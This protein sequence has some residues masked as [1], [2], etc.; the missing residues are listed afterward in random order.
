MIMIDDTTTSWGLSAVLHSLRG[1]PRY[2]DSHGVRVHDEGI[3]N[4]QLEDNFFSLICEVWADPNLPLEAAKEASDALVSF[5][6]WTR[7][8]Q[9][10]LLRFFDHPDDIADLALPRLRRSLKDIIQCKRI[11]KFIE[12]IAF[13]LDIENASFKVAFVEARVIPRIIKLIMKFVNML[14]TKPMACTRPLISCFH[15]FIQPVPRSLPISDAICAF[16]TPPLSSR[17]VNVRWLDTV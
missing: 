7:H 16:C 13:V 3:L 4:E 6:S 10:V 14:I 5:Q 17:S 12:A 15:I 8:R 11:A 9:N 2:Y 1:K